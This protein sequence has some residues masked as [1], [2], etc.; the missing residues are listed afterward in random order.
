MTAMHSPEILTVIVAVIAATGA[1]LVTGLL[2]RPKMN[3]E[4]T[5]ARSGGEVSLSADARAWADTFRQQANEASERARSAE[6]K[7][8]EAE[9]RCDA[10]DR[11]I[12]AFLDY[13]L[14]LQSQL[15]AADLTPA[16]PPPLLRPPL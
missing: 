11:K 2:Q 7:A 10:M 4:A 6:V 1:S 12:D 5:A 3:A 13:T 16:P 9:E 15:R 14:T 8:Q